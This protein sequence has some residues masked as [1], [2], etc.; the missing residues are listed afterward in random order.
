MEPDIFFGK[1]PFCRLSEALEAAADIAQNADDNVDVVI[2]PPDPLEETDEE[3]RR[4]RLYGFCVSTL[5]VH[6]FKRK[7]K[8]KSKLTSVPEP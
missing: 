2:I 3:G 1:K 6:W 5:K 7:L 4:R 8:F